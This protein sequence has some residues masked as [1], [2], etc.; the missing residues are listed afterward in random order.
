[1]SSLRV[2]RNS[3]KSTGSP[4][5]AAARLPL[6]IGQA[7]VRRPMLTACAVVSWSPD[8]LLLSLPS[9]RLRVVLGL[10]MRVPGQCAPELEGE[11][12]AVLLQ[13]VDRLGVEEH[14]LHRSGRLGGGGLPVL[15]SEGQEIGRAHV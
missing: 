9:G 12:W 2:V 10:G 7:A 13:V 4:V 14:H 5:C 11:L 6:T 3:K 8:G 15:L 1:M